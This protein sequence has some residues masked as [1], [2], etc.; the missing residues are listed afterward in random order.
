MNIKKNILYLKIALKTRGCAF[1]K[2]LYYSIKY[3]G[4]IIIYPKT[5]IHI[6]KSATLKV[7]GRL[8]INRYWNIGPTRETQ[9][10]MADNTT[11]TVN[12]N[13]SFYEGCEVTLA[14]GSSLSL[15]NGY[16]NDN[17]TIVCSSEIS[18]GNNTMI[19]NS[20]IIQ[21]S[22]FHAIVREGFKKTAPIKIGDN[23]WIG[24]RSVILKGVSIG[25]GCVVAAGSVVNKSLK[26]KVLAGGVP[27][28][29][30]RENIEWGK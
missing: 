1:F 26:E 10:F 24:V 5:Q 3:N 11:L 8:Y 6:S 13:F 30:I 20:V 4:I 25:D 16:L 21:D 17:S 7:N 2:T 18:I 28:K 22:D 9:F 15:Q 12:G 14:T 29:V 23:V 19:S 27:C